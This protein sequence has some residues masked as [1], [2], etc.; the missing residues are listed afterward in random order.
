[1][2]SV[3][4]GPRSSTKRDSFW[5]LPPVLIGDPVRVRSFD[6]I[7]DRSWLD[8]SKGVQLTVA[9][10]REQ[11]EA[12]F[13]L[14][15]PLPKAVAIDIDLQLEVNSVRGTA[16][17]L[18]QLFTV[19]AAG[20]MMPIKYA[21]RDVT[22]TVAPNAGVTIAD[23]PAVELV[24]KHPLLTV[25]TAEIRLDAEF[26]DVTELWWGL[27]AGRPT[28]SAQPRGDWY[29][30]SALG[31]HPDR[32]RILAATT[33]G[34]GPMVWM[35]WA[36]QGA[37]AQAQ[38]IQ[39]LIF[40]IAPAWLNDTLKFAHGLDAGGLTK[41]ATDGR[42]LLVVGRFLL[43]TVPSARLDAVRKST[44]TLPE[45]Q[46]WQL[47]TDVL[48][49]TV[50]GTPKMGKGVLWPEKLLETDPTTG[51][52]TVRAVL[53]LLSDIGHR[54][55]G[56]EAAADD[57]GTPLVLVYPI[58]V[59]LSEPYVFVVQAG[60]GARMNSLV[61]MLFSVGAVAR[62]AT[63][64]PTTDEMIL[65]GHS[66]GNS[67]MWASLNNN[68]ADIVKCIAFDAASVAAPE[69]HIDEIRNGVQRRN[70]KPFTLLLV[71]SPNSY[72]SLQGLS[73]RITKVESALSGNP[74]A[75]LI[76]LPAKDNQAEFW[77]PKKIRPATTPTKNPL[78]RSMLAS[79]PDSEVTSA[80]VQA[81][82]GFL[83]FHEFA[84]YG[85]QS[86]TRTFFREALDL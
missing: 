74:S 65:A 42:P 56:H 78:L 52:A 55:A 18:Q 5:L 15:D 82:W 40:L 20:T 67:Y 83:F 12:T 28:P 35:T 57:S 66:S 33:P 13:V 73:E 48:K 60:L 16:L 34:K 80:A 6:Q 41:A 11:A 49:D 27:R 86:L 71:T 46:L 3:V 4:W 70:R 1:M 8:R 72:G 76:V 23:R 63:V 58:A 77:D 59:N 39:P 7:P 2:S 81:G 68:G 30:H 51:G 47:A 64:A 44:P 31:G 54:P 69:S 22:V 14:P 25:N 61:N 84:A 53:P 32:L 29:V 50:P 9:N 10:F 45:D 37:M 75:K 79:W 62:T 85:G 21:R 36:A 24:G 38:K 17:R 19:D 26:L 43:S